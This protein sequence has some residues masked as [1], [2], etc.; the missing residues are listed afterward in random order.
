MRNNLFEVVKKIYY[1]REYLD[2]NELPAHFYNPINTYDDPTDSDVSY[3]FDFQDVQPVE[4]LE[5]TYQYSKKW[6]LKNNLPSVNVPISQLHTTEEKYLDCYQKINFDTNFY[7]HICCISEKDDKISF[8]FF[9]YDRTRKKGVKYFKIFTSCRFV[10]YSKKS[11]SLYFGSI[12]NYHK[13]RKFS[14]VC[15]RASIS[16]SPLR[17]FIYQIKSNFDENIA[18]EATKIFINSI[19]QN[20]NPNINCDE[21][22]MEYILKRNGVKLSNNWV[23]LRQNYLQPKLKDFRS[24]DFKYVDS[25]MK[26]NKL[27]GDKIRKVL[28]LLNNDCSVQ[29]FLNLNKFLGEKFV[30]SR[31][32][33][34][35][36]LF[37]RM[38]AEYFTFSFTNF[39][40]QEMGRIYKIIL[41]VLERKV[42][43][44]T[45]NDHVDF[46][47]FLEKYETMKWKSESYEDFNDEHIR[48][49]EKYQFYTTGIY[50]R[51]YS[52][53]F[54]NLLIK[55]LILDE[56]T[57]FPVLLK[58][59]SEYNMESTIQSNCVKTTLT[60]PKTL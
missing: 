3:L 6:T 31:P 55:P 27:K 33:D 10:T 18:N 17:D 15:K 32:E 43:C 42:S 11:N 46:Y 48:W 51:T 16:S 35:L 36:K 8:K 29:G 45:F 53:D 2:Y 52:Q 14:K 4:D 9:S 59:S 5:S 47:R 57:F 49:T 22:I 30:L 40:K 44:N 12:V 54:E 21:Q 7:R 34:E 58:T 56:E 41:L 60:R 38:E 19:T 26:V 50:E 25:F 24:N 23:T 39:S 37:F 28:H 20:Y 1:V 13:K